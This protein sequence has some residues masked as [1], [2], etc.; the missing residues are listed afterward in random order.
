MATRRHEDEN[1][2]KALSGVT[3]PDWEAM[4]RKIEAELN[5]RKI[6]KDAV[7]IAFAW[8]CS[9]AAR[10][11]NPTALW[12]QQNCIQNPAH[13]YHGFDMALRSAYNCGRWMSANTGKFKRED[14]NK[15]ED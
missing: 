6:F 15:N 4:D 9:S 10:R 5:I 7:F 8:G 3:V 12:L 1:I 13:R 11:C 2:E 14:G